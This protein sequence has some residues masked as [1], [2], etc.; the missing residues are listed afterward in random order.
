MKSEEK[1]IK[2]QEQF[3]TKFEKR[4][5]KILKKEANFKDCVLKFLI[6]YKKDISKY[7]GYTDE[8]VIKIAD[9]FGFKLS[10]RVEDRLSFL[11]EFTARPVKKV[12][13]IDTVNGDSPE[14]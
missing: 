7:D 2:K 11:Y 8:V 9:E 14:E 3:K 13:Y 10:T 5:R 4:C 1:R 6:V 12:K